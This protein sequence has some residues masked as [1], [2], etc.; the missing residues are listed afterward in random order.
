MEDTK[1]TITN[2]QLILPEVLS[3][4]AYK[5]NGSYQSENLRSRLSWI[6]Q[7]FRRIVFM[8]TYEWI[9]WLKTPAPDKSASSWGVVPEYFSES[10]RWL[11]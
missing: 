9:D 3:E 2:I 8:K 6:E 5:A 10:F 1:K 11:D 7:S 4:H